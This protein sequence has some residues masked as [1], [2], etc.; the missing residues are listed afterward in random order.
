VQGPEVHY[1]AIEKMALEVVFASW[2]LCHYFQIFIVVV[3]TDL[4]KPDMAG[5]MVRWA[6]EVSEFDVHYEPRGPI[7]GQI[8]VDFVVELSSES[9]QLDNGDF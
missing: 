9:T 3:M 6:V 2:R 5:R 8:Y 4:Q 7:K 1:Q